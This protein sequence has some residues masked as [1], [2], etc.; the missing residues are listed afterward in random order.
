MS[1]NLMLL[2]FIFILKA[3][4]CIVEHLNPMSFTQ[5]SLLKTGAHT[6]SVTLTGLLYPGQPQKCNFTTLLW[7]VIPGEHCLPFVWF[8][9]KL[10]TLGLWNWQNCWL[11]VR[12]SIGL[13]WKLMKKQIVITNK[14][15]SP[16]KGKVEIT[17]SATW[18]KE[19]THWKRPWC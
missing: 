5:L 3:C 4:Y 7:K 13:K 18:W 8:Y 2:I 19:P 10:S 11:L 12:F 1:L 17:T 9:H 15:I 16:L 14:I 6:H